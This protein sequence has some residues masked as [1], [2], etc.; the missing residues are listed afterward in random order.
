M[1][2]SIIKSIKAFGLL[3][4]YFFPYICLVDDGKVY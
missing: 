1:Q 3:V 2:N 4:K